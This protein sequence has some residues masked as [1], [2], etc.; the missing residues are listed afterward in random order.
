MFLNNRIHQPEQLDDFKLDGPIL[1]QS[2]RELQRINHL[3]GNVRTLSQAVMAQLGPF[4]GKEVTII[5][6]GCGS[7]DVLAAIAKKARKQQQAVQLIG[8]DA[9]PNSLAFA[10]K[11]W[12]AYPELSF[13][14]TDIMSP[15]FQLPPCDLLL[16]SHFIYH[17]ED[18]ALQ[19]FLQKQLRA[20]RYAAIFSELDRHFLALHLFKFVSLLLRFSP[21]TRRDG[22]TAIKRAFKQAELKKII[23]TLAL[24]KM[25][26]QYKWAF[27]HLLTIYP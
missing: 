8:M 22:Q 16:S 15:L 1:Y 6:L 19:Q 2:L 24:S 7:G 14:Q 9:N 10:K 18:E 21:M 3:F 4:R 12:A 13:L 23:Q 5:D 20:V 17:F 27:R 11:C 25:D 26:L